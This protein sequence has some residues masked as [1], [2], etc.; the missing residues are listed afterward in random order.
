MYRIFKMLALK[1]NM[2]R[3]LKNDSI[4]VKLIKN[5]NKSS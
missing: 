2:Y 1:Q 4:M 5:K 3:H